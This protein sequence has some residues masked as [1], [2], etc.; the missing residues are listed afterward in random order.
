MSWSSLWLC[1]MMDYIIE[2]DIFV[3]I[4]GHYFSHPRFFY[5]SCLMVIYGGYLKDNWWCNNYETILVG[6][7]LSPLVLRLEKCFIKHKRGHKELE[8]SS[9]GSN[10][11]LS[12]IEQTRTSIFRTSTN[13]NMFI[14]WWSNSNTLFLASNEQTNIKPKRAIIRFTNL[15]IK[16]TRTSIFWTINELHRVHL[17]V[18][19]LEHPIFC[20]DW[21]NIEL[22]TWFD[23]RPIT[24]RKIYNFVDHCTN[25]I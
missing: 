20:F 13:P 11:I 24:K 6:F 9:D 14:Y 2:K 1:Q 7:S 19:E 3:V 21:L 23:V 5:Y 8:E 16:Q 17:L 18:I 25:V 10:T 22:Q 12:N 15:L 4:E